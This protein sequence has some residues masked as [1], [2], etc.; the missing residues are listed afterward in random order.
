MVE[1]NIYNIALIIIGVFLINST[2]AQEW[3]D[4]RGSNRDGIWKEDGIIEKFKNN[5]IPL[6]YRQFQPLRRNAIH[7]A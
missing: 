5:I 6:K 1:R 4:W 3:P 7:L 2:E